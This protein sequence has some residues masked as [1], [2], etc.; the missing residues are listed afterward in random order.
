ME[1]KNRI[2][3]LSEEEQMRELIRYGKTPAPENLKYR[4]MQQ[5]QTEQALKSRQ[6]F[7][8]QRRRE[9]IWGEFKT[10]FGIM[11]AVLAVIVAGTFFLKGKEFFLSTQFWNIVIVV[12]SVFSIFWMITCLDS[13]L[14]EKKEKKLLPKKDKVGE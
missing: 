9:N 5:I 7:P 12:T 1:D 2:N 10:I 3:N 4:I 6:E 13:H 11:Y 14:R 8:T